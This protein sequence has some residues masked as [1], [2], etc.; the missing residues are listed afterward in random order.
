MTKK[1]LSRA[2]LFENNNFSTENLIDEDFKNLY[3]A[4]D[5]YAEQQIEKRLTFW[6]IISEILFALGM[7]FIGIAVLIFMILFLYNFLIFLKP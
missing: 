2:K 7:F 3:K 5:Q 6:K 1:I 4:M